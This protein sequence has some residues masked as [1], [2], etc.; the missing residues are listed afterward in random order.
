MTTRWSEYILSSGL[1]RHLSY[2]DPWAH[3][4]EFGEQILGNIAMALWGPQE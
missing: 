3:A 2:R 4:N 1:H